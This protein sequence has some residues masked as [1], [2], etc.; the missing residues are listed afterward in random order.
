M[1]QTE[2]LFTGNP[3]ALPDTISVPDSEQIMDTLSS[4][5][6]SDALNKF[7]S[8]LVDFSFKLIIAI[9]VFYLGKF[10]INKLYRVVRRVM[11]ARNTDASLRSF[12]LSLMRITLYFILIVTVIGILGIETSSFLALFASAGVAIG[13]ALSGTLQ[14]FAGGVLILLLKPYRVGDFIEVQGYS[15]TV[16]SIQI[17]HTIINTVDN[18]AIIIPN[19]GLSTGSINNFSMEHFR[20][21]EWNIALSYSTDLEKAK[22]AI[23]DILNSDE[24]VLQKFTAEDHPASVSTPEEENPGY[25][26]KGGFWKRLWHRQRKRAE[27]IQEVVKAS[28]MEASAPPIDCSPFVALN[29][30]ADSSINLKV[31]AWTNSAD[32]WALFFAMNERFFTELPQQG[33]SF[34][35]PQ[36]DVHMA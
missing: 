15:G 32:Y 11:E 16:K 10:I 17:F 26:Q 6:L 28:P 1:I 13:M 19:G 36:L 7:A 27:K 4:L 5:S 20:R 18:K 33:F 22:Q 3:T 34:P 24:R 23:L 35:F 30:M 12:V 14:N 9:L 8:S 25:E 2:N 31:R 29:E 21:V